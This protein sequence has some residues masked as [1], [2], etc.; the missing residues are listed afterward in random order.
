MQKA[1]IIH[2]FVH[3]NYWR[4]TFFLSAIFTSHFTSEYASEKRLNRNLYRSRMNFHARTITCVAAAIVNCNPKRPSNNKIL[5]WK[6]LAWIQYHEIRSFR[7]FHNPQA[8]RSINIMMV[9]W[10]RHYGCQWK[11]TKTKK[12]YTNDGTKR[13]SVV[14]SNVPKKLSN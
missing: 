3:S 9:I 4:N 12:N 7:T 6:P 2:H 13:P 10:N 1:I 5:H 14:S 8:F 11:R